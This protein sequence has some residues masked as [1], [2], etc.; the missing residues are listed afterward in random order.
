MTTQND[1][2]NGSDPAGSVD[3]SN[4]TGNYRSSAAERVQQN[5][6][7]NTAAELEVA[8]TVE[9][10]AEP[11]APPSPTERFPWMKDTRQWGTRATP[12][13]HGL[14]IDGINVG[15]YGEIPEE[16]REMTRMPRGSFA[17]PGIPRLDN[18][19]VNRKDE[20]WS[21][22]SAWLYEEAI[23]RRWN[24]MQD[25]PWDDIPDQPETPGTGLVPAVHRVGTARHRRDRHHRPVAAPDELR[26]H[27]AQD[28]PGHPGVRLGAA[29]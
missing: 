23:Q 12:T 1:P 22:N 14:T 11:E 28:V 19:S 27:R 2:Q 9:A 8:E 6:A 24:A 18:Y 25:I 5:V 3:D 7:D 4:P 10:P 29:L 26:L 13:A 21:D 16:S 17:T 20:L 15:L